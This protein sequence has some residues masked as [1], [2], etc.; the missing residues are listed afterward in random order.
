VPV[1]KPD[2]ILSSNVIPSATASGSGQS[3]FNPDD[4]SSDGEEYL[5]P[6]NEADMTPGRCDC[7]ARSLTAARLY[8]NSQPEAPNNWG[9]I[10]PNLNDYHCD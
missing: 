5:T 8:S 4:W 6:N 2:S 3:S 9:Q 10:N 1:N 7:T